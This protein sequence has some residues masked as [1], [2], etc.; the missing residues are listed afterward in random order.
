M[1]VVMCR[2]IMRPVARYID[3]GSWDR[4]RTNVN[5]C[6]RVL[7]LRSRMREA[8]EQLEGDEFYEGMDIMGEIANTMSQLDASLYT[9]LFI[10]SD[11]GVSVEQRK[12]QTQ[13]RGYYKEA[14]EYLDRFL[15]IMP[16]DSLERAE[17][18]ANEARYEIK[19]DK[20]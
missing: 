4:G 5:Y 7:A 12:Y 15:G 16:T 20:E 2:T 18:V 1:P 14:V 3:E 17:K 11:E 9:P 19:M 10:A 13:A 6:T 8:A